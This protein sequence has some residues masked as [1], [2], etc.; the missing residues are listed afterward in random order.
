[1]GQNTNR[2]TAVSNGLSE[3]AAAAVAILSRLGEAERRSALHELGFADIRRIWTPR[4]PGSLPTLTGL[5]PERD[6]AEIYAS[7]VWARDYRRSGTVVVY[8]L[9]AVGLARLSVLLGGVSLAKVGS[10][11]LE[12]VARRI[13]E[14]GA[15]Q[16]GAWIRGPRRYEL[17]PGFD[18][19]SIR[20]PPRMQLAVQHPSSPVRLC[21]YGI[22]VDLPPGMSPGEF[23]AA[24]NH[25]LRMLRLQSIGDSEA[26]RAL[27]AST[28]VAPAELHRFYKRKTTFRAATEIT[29]FRPQADLGA[30]ARL[31][32]DIV[33]DHV[34][35]LQPKRPA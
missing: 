3:A 26:G 10:T 28:G 32:E 12:N 30:L 23:E 27:C 22:E 35:N 24:L 16:Y 21:A 4:D 25:A 15:G 14:L 8:I 33:I 13:A 20:I 6:R 18:R 1:M 29:L 17:T 7:Q 34:G 5:V 31:C 19:F 2:M 9:Q 11:G